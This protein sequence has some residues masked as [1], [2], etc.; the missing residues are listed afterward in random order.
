[1]SVVNCACFIHSTHLELQKDQV[2]FHLLDTLKT[3]GLL[4]ELRYLCI[5]NTG[6][7]LDAKR[8]ESEYVPAKVIQYSF[9]TLEFEN[10]SIR[11]LYTFAKL[12]PAYKILYLHTKGV[13]YH[14]TH[15]FYPGVQSWNKYMMHCLVERFPQCLS[16]LQIYDTV[17]C[18]YRKEEDGNPPHYSGNFWW[19]NASYLQTLSID[20][21][22]DKYDPEFWLL[23]ND[24]LWFNVY[25]LEHMYEQAY[26]LDDYQSDVEYS[27]ENNVFFCKVGF[28]KTGLCNQLYC[29]ANVVSIAAAQHG[30]GNKI[31]ILDDFIT[32]INMSA[33]RPS[34]QILDIPRCNHVLSEKQ[35]HLIYK[36]DI[37]MTLDKVE[38]GLNHIRVLD[39]TKHIRKLFWTLNHLYIPQGTHLNEIIQE[40]PCPQMRKQ[41]RVFYSINGIPLQKVFHE[42]L[43]L[44]SSPIEIN[45][46][47]FD[48]KKCSYLLDCSQ[49]WLTRINRNDSREKIHAFNH[50]LKTVSFQKEY[51]EKAEYFF[52]SVC[53]QHE[54]ECE[55]IANV[56][57]LHIRNESDAIEHW[58]KMNQMT[59]EEFQE[60]YERQYI[61]CVT[62][63]LS[64]HDIH[65]ALTSFTDGNP[66]I[67]SLR[68][69]GYKIYCRSNNNDTPQREINAIID[70]II[71][72]SYGNSFFIGNLNPETFQG[73]TFSN[74]LCQQMEP[75]VKKLVLNI[76]NILLLPTFI[77]P[78][79][80][81]PSPN[82]R[83][84]FSK[85]YL[86]PVA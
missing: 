2:L 56:N 39:I 57:I 3:S 77:I 59:Q 46:S 29:I 1:M 36:H 13:S 66:I 42:R 52:Q 35:I 79:E 72:S 9:N 50:F 64:K 17:G 54:S 16:L 81:I 22:K 38:Y 31:I 80:N 23:Q 58:S 6:L 62:R 28:C 75:T 44:D 20:Y 67:E 68:L 25:T 14:P 45:Y 7:P 74:V 30:G 83:T 5:M 69:L 33:H 86:V 24:P 51:Y 41:V 60:E 43:L 40:D 47:H 63:H 48:G 70:L 78:S 4:K 27:M 84:L 37:T 8:I 32:D 21:L 12:N 34:D 85:S 82:T 26:P 61:E 10:V 53:H 19:A 15:V 18:N 76:E 11:T 55:T 71:G 73:S 65:L 49:P